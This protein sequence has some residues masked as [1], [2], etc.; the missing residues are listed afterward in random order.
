MVSK[1]RTRPCP[2]CHGIGY[3]GRIG[4]FEVMVLDDEARGVLAT[5]QLNQ[6]RAH[7]RRRKMVY[8]Q[9]VALL[10]AVEGMTSVSEVN[11]SL[12]TR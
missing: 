8:L 5:G 12:A 9:E 2:E 3:R 6:F 1:D 11:R 10:K 4:V 7:L